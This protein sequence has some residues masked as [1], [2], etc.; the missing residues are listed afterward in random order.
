MDTI[1][2]LNE[3]MVMMKPRE[4]TGNSKF[5]E[6]KAKIPTFGMGFQKLSLNLF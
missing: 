2:L 3:P 4:I 1:N 6:N 5:N